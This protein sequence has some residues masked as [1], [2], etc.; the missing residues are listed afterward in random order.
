[1]KQSRWFL[2]L[3]LVFALFLMPAAIGLHAQ[4]EDAAGV[5]SAP[6]ATTENKSEGDENDVYRHSPSVQWVANTLHVNVETAART[7]EWINC[8]I[9]V[10]PVVWLLFSFLPKTFKKRNAVIAG[11]IAE[12]Q[13]ASAQ[14]SA[15]LQVV[16]ARLANLDTEIAGIRSQVDADAE[17]D[18]KRH[19]EQVEEEKRRIVETA[20]QEI[21]AASQAAQR[22]LKRYAAQIALEG[23]M[24]QLSLSP[25]T[26]RELVNEFAQALGKGREN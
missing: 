4:S 24:A 1:M 11:K 18:Q 8:A 23:A 6:A 17:R 10:L 22:E 7:M 14:A 20:E 25:E 21:V 12:A 16:E 26:D 3:A 15:R 9:V 13:T 2:R 5:K 19:T